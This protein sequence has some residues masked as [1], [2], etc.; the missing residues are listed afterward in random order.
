MPFSPSQDLRLSLGNLQQEISHA[1]ERVWH[2]GVSNVPFVGQWSPAVDLHEYPDRYVLYAELP[3][4]SGGDVDLACLDNVLTIRGERKVPEGVD[5][6]VR[7]VRQERRLGSFSR[8]IELPSDSDSDK[9]SAK[10]HAGVLK[11][12][13]LKCETARPT[14]IKID[15]EGGE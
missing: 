11:V 10:C 9:V 7:I 14:S 1:I 8:A 13:I 5:D 2:E 3:G 6:E 12:T 15:I 4:L